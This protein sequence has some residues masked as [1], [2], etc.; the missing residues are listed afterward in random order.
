MAARATTS[1]SR[2]FS[3]AIHA[4][5]SRSDPGCLIDREGTLLFA[6]DAWDRFALENGGGPSCCAAALTGSRIYDHVAGEEPRRMLR[7]LVERVLR[8]AAQAGPH[9]AVATSECNSPDSAR[10]VA[11]QLEPVMAG[12]EVL[13]L[14][15]VHRVVRQLPAADVYPVVEGRDYHGPDEA[16]E[17]C[18]C[19]RRTRRPD[20][21]A[22]WDFVPALV[23]V[24]PRE[25][26]FGYCPLC[27][28]LHH[29]GAPEREG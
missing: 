22:E 18:S 23:A 17:Q 27:R 11:L 3:S 20:D 5:A 28:E 7:M 10:L 14:V 15:L 26:R 13:G 4:L 21:P 24:T 8:Q 29:A 1:R 2:P 12:T 9:R 6:N 25:A 16:I 19:C